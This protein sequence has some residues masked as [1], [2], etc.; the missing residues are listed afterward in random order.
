MDIGHQHFFSELDAVEWV[1][2]MQNRLLH[3]HLHDNDGTGDKHWSIGRGT[4]DFEAFFAALMRYV[5]QAT[6]SLEVVDKM[7]VRMSDLRKLAGHFAS[8]R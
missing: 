8:K 5:P 3:V 6:I 4:I 2:R 1:R 7:D